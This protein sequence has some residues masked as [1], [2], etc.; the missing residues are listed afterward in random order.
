MSLFD[1]Q[2]FLDA[3]YTESN[4]TKLIPV[5]VGEYAAL[6]EKVT[7]RTWQ[8]KDGTQSGVALDVEWLIED[9]EVKS[10]LGRETIKCRQ[11]LMLDLTQDGKLDMSKGKNIGLGKLREA[12]NLNQAGQQF[13][14]GQLPGRMAKVQ[15][16]HRDNEKEAGEVFAEIRK[17]AAM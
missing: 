10:F 1:P 8:S 2:A 7:P 5:P 3:A 6:I 17:V 13:S 11:G 4:D 9:Q 15:V 16:T 14:F 12:L